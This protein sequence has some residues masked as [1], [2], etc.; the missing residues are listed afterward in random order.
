MEY[1]DIYDIDRNFLN[2][3]ILRGEE[4]KEGEFRLAVSVIVINMEGKIL[5]TL[6]SPAKKT[7]PNKWENTTGAVSAGE[8]MLQ[9]GVR[10]LYEETGIIIE[11]T[12]LQKI[13][14]FKSGKL[15]FDTFIVFKDISIQDIKLDDKETVYAKIVTIDE[16]DEMVEKGEVLEP[17]AKVYKKILKEKILLEC[18]RFFSTVNAT[19]SDLNTTVNQLKE[20]I[21]DF[22]I[23]RNFLETENAKDLS[24]ALSVECSELLSIF[25][26]VHSDKADDIKYNEKLFENLKE[27]IADVFWYLIRLCEHYD[28]DLTQAVIDKEVKNINKY[29]IR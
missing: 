16:F 19:K 2:K 28:I 3:T 27:E 7:S 11:E 14:E 6:R 15:L 5:T 22:S 9:A 21:K 1:C 20:K 24:M 17:Q 4:L 26:W 12:D 13:C 23:E 29:P 18:N 25:Q 10:E 8:T